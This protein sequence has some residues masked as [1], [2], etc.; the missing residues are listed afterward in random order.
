MYNVRE[1]LGARLLVLHVTLLLNV[2]L[3]SHTGA[4][5]SP[6]SSTPISTCPGSSRRCFKVLCP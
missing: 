5:W 3:A 2:E 4:D 1:N 6:N